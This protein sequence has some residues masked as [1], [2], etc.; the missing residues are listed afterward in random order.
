ML[1]NLLMPE[2]VCY[3]VQDLPT[4]ANLRDWILQVDQVFRIE[5]DKDTVHQLFWSKCK[6]QR[7][8]GANVAAMFFHM[9]SKDLKI[10]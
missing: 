8:T 10:M 2:G 5:V 3:K 1:K 9:R 6:D 4:L 7:F